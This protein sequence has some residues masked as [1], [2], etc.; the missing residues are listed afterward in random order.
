MANYYIEEFL[1]RGRAPGVD[2]PTAWQVTVGQ[3]QV[4]PDGKV[5]CVIVGVFTPKTAKERFGLDIGAVSGQALAQ[6]F[7]DIASLDR[8]LSE[9]QEKARLAETQ[10]VSAQYDLQRAA[11]SVEAMTSL[12]E[13]AESRAQTVESQR[14]ETEQRLEDALN[15][16]SQVKP[17]VSE[18]AEPKRITTK[19]ILHALTLGLYGN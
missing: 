1:W 17:E 11:A 16:L 8:K 10:A 7:E 9:S 6:A 13:E 2:Q 18:P 3:Y 14:A 19:P 5:M 15:L 4:T 12:V